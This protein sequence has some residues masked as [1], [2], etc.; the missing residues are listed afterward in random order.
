MV[1]LIK[2]NYL[3]QEVASKGISAF[4]SDIKQS[5]SMLEGKVKCF[6]IPLDQVILPTNLGPD[7]EE[8]T[9]SL[10]FMVKKTLKKLDDDYNFQDNDF[11]KALKYK[12]PH[13]TVSTIQRVSYDQK[14]LDGKCEEKV[15]LIIRQTIYSWEEAGRKDQEEALLKSYYYKIEESIDQWSKGKAGIRSI[16]KEVE[17]RQNDLAEKLLIAKA[18]I[19]KYETTSVQG[20]TAGVNDYKEA[21]NLK[22]DMQKQKLKVMVV[23]NLKKKSFYPLF[24]RVTRNSRAFAAAHNLRRPWDDDFDK[25]KADYKDLNE[26][27][28]ILNPDELIKQLDRVVNSTHFNFEGMELMSKYDNEPY[29]KFKR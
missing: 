15:S 28:I 3:D 18:A 8:S 9:E 23:E 19:P 24:E 29:E 4:R 6:A 14:G 25:Y 1:D 5:F 20:A 27:R 11:F 22:T 17:R 10:F 21:K 2:D 7:K 26:S 12:S 13:G 16:R